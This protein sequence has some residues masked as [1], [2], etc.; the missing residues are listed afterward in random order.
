[1]K[2]IMILSWALLATS[3]V[4]ATIVHRATPY[5]HQVPDGELKYLA[6]ASVHLL[7]ASMLTRV[8]WIMAS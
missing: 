3:A 8:V 5:E 4:L 6:K 7:G 1:M 2:L